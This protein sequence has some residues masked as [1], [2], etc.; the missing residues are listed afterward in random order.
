VSAL[1]QALD[2][3]LPD[4]G[5]DKSEGHA[6]TK[7]RPQPKTSTRLH[8]E[9]D[10]QDYQ[11]V[12]SVAPAKAGHL[13]VRPLNGGPRLLASAAALKLRGFVRS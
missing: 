6:A 7:A 5:P 3:A 8:V 10:G 4:A 1:M 12:L 11:L 13:Y 9:M 2:H